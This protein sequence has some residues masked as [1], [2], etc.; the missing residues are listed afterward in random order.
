MLKEKTLIIHNAAFDLGFLHQLGY[1]HEGEVIDTMLLSQLLYA[2]ANVPPPKTGRTSHA[3]DAV[4]ER[5]LGEALDKEHQKA[6]W[7]GDLTPEMIE[8][9]ARD[10]HV[11]IPLHQ[12]LLQKTEEAGLVD[13]LVIEQ[14]AQPAIVWMSRSG[15]PFDKD[16]WLE[17]AG[18]AKEEAARLN[19]RLQEMAPPHPEGKAWNWNSVP[20]VKQALSMLGLEA[21]NTRDETLA[22]LDHPFVRTLRKYKKKSGIA[23]R[24]GEKWLRSKD[25]ADRVTGGR[26]YPSWK[27]IGA[28][29]GRMA[30][31]EPNLQAIPHGHGHHSCV[32]ATEGR[33]L[34]KADYSQIELRL[35]AKLWNEPVMLEVFRKGGDIHATTARSITG[36]EEITKEERKLAKAVNFGLIFGQGAEGLRNYARNNYGVEMTLLEAKRYRE[37]FFESYPAI[38]AWHRR[39][40]SSFD[41]G[42][43]TARSLAGRMRQVGS[44]TEKINHPVQ[45]AAADGMK[46]ALALLWERREECPGAVPV[47]AVHDEIV[48]ECDEEDAEKAKTWLVKAMKDGMDAVVN[49]SE[50]R[51][52]IEVEASVVQTWGD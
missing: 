3:L 13:T 31:A 44:F 26:M 11:L 24:H 19:E 12:K 28:A 10:A 30:C 38:R 9:A 42:D 8:Y 40:G 22:R 4:A 2:G 43:V 51:V 6:D 15:L 14:R 39:E 27:Q 21:E 20:Q 1:E 52:P 23:T 25:G 16:Q 36:K 29:T 50:P 49:V 48:V 46:L 45:G 41:N 5:E 17:I 18:E 35:A 34:T 47:L 32:R 7:A 33:V 37:R